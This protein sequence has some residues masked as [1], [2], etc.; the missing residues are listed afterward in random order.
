MYYFIRAAE[1]HRE[2]VDGLD[3]RHL[4]NEA[5]FGCTDF[6]IVSKSYWD[7]HQE[8]NITGPHKAEIKEECPDFKGV[9]VDESTYGVA[10]RPEIAKIRMLKWGL[11][12]L[13]S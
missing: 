4:E 2:K 3:K 7:E 1:Y 11:K 13:P 5:E 6:Y 9:V 10:A 8:L 12:E